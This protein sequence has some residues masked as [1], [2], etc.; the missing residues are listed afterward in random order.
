VR[1]GQQSQQ[2]K[3]IPCRGE[4]VSAPSISSVSIVV[5]AFTA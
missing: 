2:A 3:S 1:S 4:V 5:A